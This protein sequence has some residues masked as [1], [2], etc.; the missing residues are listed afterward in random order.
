EAERG[1]GG[2]AGQAAGDGDEAV[3]GAGEMCRT[4]LDLQAPGGS[5]VA[6][7]VAAFGSTGPWPTVGHGAGLA[8]VLAAAAVRSVRRLICVGLDRFSPVADRS[9]LLGGFA[10]DAALGLRLLG[11]VL[12]AR[13]SVMLVDRE[14]RWSGAVRRACRRFSVQHRA[15]ENAYP[16][17]DPTVVIGAHTPGRARLKPGRDPLEAGVVLVEPWSVIRLARW[18][19]RGRLDVVRPTFVSWPTRRGGLSVRWAWPGEAVGGWLGVDAVGEV[20]AGGQAEAEAEVGGVGAEGADRRR[21]VWGDAMGGEATG[22]VG[23]RSGERGEVVVG[24]GDRPGCWGQVLSVLPWGEAARASACVSCGWCVEV[25]PT[26]LW[27]IELLER[28]RSRP[29]EAQVREELSWCVDCG[30]CSHVCP[31]QIPLAEGLR[32]AAERSVREAG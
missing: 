14:V 8:G 17:A 19:T 6:D 23:W 16:S 22:A 1:L 5:E 15:V 9:S 11:E 28:S 30:L 18:V 27:P 20:E 7:W 25:C 21:V 24:A 4:W 32:S 12:G 26:R 2:G 31:S 10:D 29:G 13:R 3:G